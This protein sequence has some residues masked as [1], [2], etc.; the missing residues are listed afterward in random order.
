M[1]FKVM[2][3]FKYKRVKCRAFNKKR[4][5]LSRL[6]VC[7]TDGRSPKSCLLLKAKDIALRAGDYFLSEL[8]TFHKIGKNETNKVASPRKLQSGTT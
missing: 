8:I 7:F 4:R 1:F 6:P 3:I 5:Q 2:R